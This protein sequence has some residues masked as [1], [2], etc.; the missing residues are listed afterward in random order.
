[1]TILYRDVDESGTLFVSKYEHRIAIQL[2]EAD[3]PYVLA[4]ALT[5][6]QARKMAR[7]ILAIVDGSEDAQ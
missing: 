3:V 4:R 6:A 7:A 1:M 2:T 5:K